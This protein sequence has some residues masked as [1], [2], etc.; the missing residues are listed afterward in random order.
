LIVDNFK[1]IGKVGVKGM[2]NSLT[3]IYQF[4]DQ[5]PLEGVNYYRIRVV[6]IDKLEHLSSIVAIYPSK[7]QSSLQVYPNPVEGRVINVAIK[8]SE[9]GMY[10]L[11]IYNIEGQL[12]QEE[13]RLV[14][15]NGY[16]LQLQ[17]QS[18]IVSGMYLLKLTDSRGGIKKQ[19]FIL[20]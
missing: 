6:D 9:A 13:Q 11:G 3:N 15:A 8:T 1:T 10:N 4:E 20:K 18:K 5:A 17:L 16:N 2:N 14:L 12:L 19:I 7:M